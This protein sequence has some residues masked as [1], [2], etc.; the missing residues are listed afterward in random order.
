MEVLYGVTVYFLRHGQ[1]QY[2]VEKRFYGVTDVGLSAEGV[3]EALNAAGFLKKTVFE[4]VYASP[5]SRARETAEI[6][7]ERNAAPQDIAYIEGLREVDFGDWEGMK[8][9]D[10][11]ERFAP[12]WKVYIEGFGSFTFPNG[13]SIGAYNERTKNYMEGFVKRHISGNILIV[14]HKGFI[15]SAISTMLHGDP[16]SMFKYDLD[17]GKTAI[18][19]TFDDFCILKALNV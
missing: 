5:L 17:T 3:A 12:D 1:T 16:R 15:L 18:V 11:E 4:A 13:D 6:V 9:E 19:E 7:M 10:I 14:S 2:N 8:A